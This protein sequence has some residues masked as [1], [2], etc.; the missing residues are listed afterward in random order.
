MDPKASEPDQDATET[1]AAEAETPPEVGGTEAP[2]LDPAPESAPAPRR[3]RRRRRWG[4]MSCGMVLAL[5]VLMAGF[6]VLSLGREIVAPAWVHERLER[7]VSAMMPGGQA[8]FGRVTF[9][10]SSTLRPR[11]VLQEVEV[12]GPD[13]QQMIALG[14]LEVR[15]AKAPL[16]EGKMRLGRVALSGAEVVVRRRSDGSFDLAFGASLPDVEQAA[17]P[18]ELVVGLDQL[19]QSDELASLRSL[20]ADALILRFEDQRAGRAW[21]VDGG[22]FSLE[23]DGDDLRLRG[24]MALLGGHQYVTSV[25]VNYESRIGATAAQFGMTFEDMPGRDIAAQ[26]SALAWLEAVQAPISGALRGGLTETGDF[27]PLS[28]TLQVAE[29]VIQPTP[30]TNPVP[31]RSARSYFTF[32]PETQALRFDELS[33]DSN[34]IAV[35]A[36]GQAILQGGEDGVPDAFLGQFTLA[37]LRAKPEGVIA[38]PIAVDQASMSFR[39]NLDPFELHLGELTATAEGQT[40]TLEGRARA[41][42]EGW[43]MS[44]GAHAATLDPKAVLRL[45]PKDLRVKNRTWVETNILHAVLRNAQLAYRS[46]PGA[47]PDI[48]AGFEFEEANVR[49]SRHLP[50]VEQGRGHAE[51]L[52]KRFTVTGDAG[53][54]PTPSGGQ[55]DVAGT[56][57]VIPDVTIKPAPAEV[58][59]AATGDLTA[60]LSFLN[61]HPLSVL[62]KAGRGLD[63]A[64]G[65]MQARGQLRMPL[66]KG[67]PP[68]RVAYEVEAVLRDV[69][70]TTLVPNKV[71]RADQLSLSVDNER[72]VVLGPAEVDGV[73]VDAVYEGGLTPETRGRAQVYGTIEVTSKALDAFNISLPA[74]MVKG[75]GEAQISLDLVKGEPPQF[76]LESDLAGLGL[77]IAPLG[78]SLPQSRGGQFQMSGRLGQPVTVDRIALSAPGLEAVGRMSLAETGGLQA[79]TLDRLRVGGWL[80]AP[81]TL[82]GRGKGRAPAVEVRG[83]Q[84]DLAKRPSGSNSSGAGGTSGAT[85]LQVNLDRLVISD[86]IELR[87]FQG[88][89]QSSGGLQGRFTGLLNGSAPVT[90]Q[91]ASQNGRSRYDIRSADA[92]AVFGAMKLLKQARGGDLQLSLT[93]ASGAGQLD[94]T[95]KV[96]DLRVIEVPALASLLNAVSIVGLLDQLSGPGILFTDVEAQFRL[97]P[98]QM[99]LQRSSAVGASMGISMDGI[100]TFA[101]KAMDF[102]GVLSPIYALNGIGSLLTRKGEGLLGF[103]YTLKGPSSGPRVQVNPLSI[104]T[105]GM[106]R[107]IFRRPAPKVTQ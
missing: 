99:I 19:L 67:L 5:L 63:L 86:S 102:Q 73:A 50:P 77:S 11:V 83:G 23:R 100:Y 57:F 30:E 88:D 76:R 104:F 92:G 61:L 103:N 93:P 54:I 87:A 34:W 44:F 98:D 17:S 24:D 74:G 16:L 81:V 90:G 43:Q 38:S 62:D 6:V 64:T 91:I 26:T 51:L 68:D 15:L 85:P 65:W 27:T 1:V 40:V 3:R 7:R 9:E 33:V 107:E 12:D 28:G 80:D 89:L 42:R 21:T 35:R 29:G 53:W 52:G 60:A 106:F 14:A 79:L 66:K 75:A 18:A 22:R 41:S 46:T 59:V 48:Y 95:L 45:W 10:M 78:W 20:T 4:L 97:T 69:T 105:P 13:G 39:L 71:L 8:R 49:Y 32:D 101:G 58:N 37:D 56:T 47:A 2:S 82:R 31:F 36:E 25:E 55:L 84:M 72:L 70:S 94:G 96:K